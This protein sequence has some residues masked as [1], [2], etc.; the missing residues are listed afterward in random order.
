MSSPSPD[1]PAFRT[2]LAVAGGLVV[3]LTLLVSAF[4][5]PP[6]ELEPRSLPVVVV[7]DQAVAAEAVAG[8]AGAAGDDAFDVRAVAGRAEAVAA[9]EDRD[10]Y[11]AFLPAEGELLVASAAGPTVAQLLTQLA[12]AR[13][14]ATTVTDVVPTPDDDPRG[15]VFT[16]AALPLVLGGIVT[17]VLTSVVLTRTRD[18][19]AGAV[20]VAVVGGLALCAVVQGWL[21]AIRGSYLANGA[22]VALGI[23]AVALTI[24]G[25]RHVLGRPGIAV[26]A[27]LMLLVGNPLSGVSSAPELIPLGSWGQLLPPGAFGTALRGTAFFDGAG[28]TGPLLVLGTWVAAGLLLALVPVRPG[29]GARPVPG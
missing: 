17:G 5:W 25:L 22:V 3:L 18:R 26:G 4:T 24:V 1:A 12:Q 2:V 6:S 23:G 20:L 14:P 16:A 28:V 10:A 7:G 27:L 11:G 8:L 19:V 13:E 9:I 21:G 29:H 15:A